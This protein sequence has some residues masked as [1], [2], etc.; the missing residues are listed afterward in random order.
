MRCDPE[1]VDA[2]VRVTPLPAA[3]GLESHLYGKACAYMVFPIFLA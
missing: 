1:S 3:S 2:T